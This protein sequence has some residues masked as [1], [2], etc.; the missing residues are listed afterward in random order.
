[1]ELT[2]KKIWLF[3]LFV[4][5]PEGEPMPDC[6]LE[7]YRSLQVKEKLTIL[8][9]LSEEEVE[10]IINHHHQCVLRRV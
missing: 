8:E 1:M 2:D 6:P 10:E 7:K 5:C 3:G 4:A 9:K